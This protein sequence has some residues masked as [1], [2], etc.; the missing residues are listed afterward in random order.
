MRKMIC[1]VC[2]VK[3]NKLK[4]HDES[5]SGNW[6]DICQIC[7]KPAGTKCVDVGRRSTVKKHYHG[8][9]MSCANKLKKRTE[10]N[11]S[12]FAVYGDCK[13]CGK[14]G[15]LRKIYVRPREIYDIFKDENKVIK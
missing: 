2:A 7:G 4:E 14:E 11:K 8:V 9:C 3:L 15:S 10:Y 13:K 1:S 6:D 12:P 5:D